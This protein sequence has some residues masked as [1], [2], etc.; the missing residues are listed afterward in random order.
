MQGKNS[1]IE[2]VQRNLFTSYEGCLMDYE[3]LSLLLEFPVADGYKVNF[4]ACEGDG[5]PKV[6]TALETL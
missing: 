3:T 1:H 6:P 5:S 2:H 4:P